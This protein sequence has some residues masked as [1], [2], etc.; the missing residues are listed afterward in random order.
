M[1]LC[2]ALS[3]AIEKL[4]TVKTIIDLLQQRALAHG[5][6]IL[7]TF[8]EDGEGMESHLSYTALTERVSRL[9]ERLKAAGLTGERVLLFYPAGL[10][11]IVGFFS[12]LYAGITAVPLYPPRKNQSILRLLSVITDAKPAAILTTAQIAA[13]VHERFAIGE[14]A[15]IQWIVDDLATSDTATA[16]TPAAVDTHDI[17]FLQ[18]T[19]GS[20]GNPK[21]V[22]V[23]HHNLLRNQEMIFEAYGNIERAVVVGWLPLYH[24]MGLIGNLLQALYAGGRLCFMSPFSFLQ[25]PYR[26]LQ[27]I[28]RYKGQIC[29]G[30]NFAYEL[31]ADRI[32]EA[33]LAALD[34]SSWRVAFNGAEPVHAG[35][36][37]K[38][39]GRFSSCGFRQDAFYPCY[40]MA[41]A[42]LMVSGTKLAGKVT[43]CHVD[44]ALMEQ[45]ILHYTERTANSD[46]YTRLVSCGLPVQQQAIIVDPLTREQQPEHMIGEIWIR[47]DNVT[48]GY[49]N[50]ETATRDA[51]HA[52]TT[53]TE[54]RWLRTGDLG[55]LKNGELYVTG[56]LKDLIIIRG[57]NIYPQ[58][59]ERVMQDAHPALQPFAGA[60]FA[61]TADNGE[62]LVVVQELQRSHCLHP[63]VDNVVQAIRTAITQHYEIPVHA[64][65]LL[66]TGTIFKTSSGKIQR[67][68]CK[69]AFLEGEGLTVLGTWQETAY[70]PLREQEQAKAAELPQNNPVSLLV[71]R[72]RLK[73]AIAEQCRMNVR[74][75]KDDEGFDRLGLDSMAAVNVANALS[76][77]LAIEVSPTLLYD[78]PGIAPLS[79]YLYG[80]V[81]GSGH[82]AAAAGSTALPEKQEAV[83]VVGMACRFP[84]AAGIH[85]FWELLRNGR[86]GVRT[87]TDDRWGPLQDTS[88]AFIKQGGFLDAIDTFDA[89]F[90]GIPDHEAAKMDPQQRLLLEVSWE[91]FEDAG[92]AAN[93]LGGQPVG[94]FV[95]ISASDYTRL[96]RNNTRLDSWNG[97]GN[98]LSIAANRLSYFYDLRGPSI[99]IDTACSSSLVAV[100]QARKSLL[101]GECSMAVAAGVNIMSAPDLSLIFANA[102]MLSPDGACKTFD[103]AAN[104]YVRGEGCGVI[105]LKRLSD[106]ERDGDRIYGIMKGSAVNQD[107]RTNGL[108]APNGPSQEAVI[109]AALADAGIAP[110][111]VNLLEAHGTGTSLGDPIEMNAL[112]QV[113][114]QNRAAEAPCYIGSVKTNIGHLEAAAG[115]A[116]LMKTLLCL[117]HRYIVPHLHIKQ[118]NPRIREQQ[119]FVIPVAATPLPDNAAPLVAGVSAFGFGGTNAHVVALEANRATSSLVTA[120]PELILLSAHNEQAL[121]TRVQQLLAF[122]QQHPAVNLHDVAG[123]CMQGRQALPWRLS[124]TANNTSDLQAKLSAWLQG[125]AAPGE[126][127]PPV[128]APAK[129]AFLFTGQGS[130]YSMMAQELYET[131]PVFRETLS[132]CSRFLE[133]YLGV[134]LVEL[135]YERKDNERIHETVITQP[136]LFSIEIS[137]AKLWAS[138]GITPGAVIGHSVGEVAAACLAGVF[139]LEDA[140]QLIATRSSLMQSL[141][142]GGQM[143]A[144]TATP[145]QV[146]PVIKEYAQFISI[147]SINAPQ[148]VIISGSGE[149]LQKVLPI[150][151][152]MQVR[153]VQL[154]VSHAF[155]SPLMQPIIAAF[156]EKIRHIQF[157]PPLIPIVSNVSGAW[158]TNDICTP[159]Y[160][161]QHILAPVLFTT[162]ISVLQQENFT[163][164]CETGPHPVLTSLARQTLGAAEDLVMLP[165]I[166]NRSGNREDMLKSLGK[167]FVCGHPVRTEA[168]YPAGSFHKLSLPPYPFQRKR[169]WLSGEDM[170]FHAGLPE[171][172]GNITQQEE[173][174]YE[175]IWEK[176]PAP[177]AAIAPEAAVRMVFIT[178]HAPWLA[179]LQDTTLGKNARCLLH[180]PGAAD[181]YYALLQEM[182]A[183]CG[184][185]QQCTIILALHPGNADNIHP[186]SIPEQQVGLLLDIVQAITRLS[187]K[188]ASCNLVLLTGSYNRNS[189]SPLYPPAAVPAAIMRVARQEI[190]ELNIKTIETDDLSASF[191]ESILAAELPAAS[192][193][194]TEVAYMNGERYVSRLRAHTPLSAPTSFSPDTDSLW[195]ITGA[196][197]AIAMH[198]LPWLISKG[199]RYFLLVSRRDPQEHQLQQLE[200]LLAPLHGKAYW[201]HTDIANDNALTFLR[202]EI[203]AT[204]KKLEGIVHLAGVLRDKALFHTAWSDMQPVFQP[205]VNGTWMLHQLSLECNPS[206]FI[207]FS[208]VAALLG[209]AHQGSYAAANAF[210]DALMAWRRRQGL[211]AISIQWGPWEGAGM[212][213]NASSH[214]IAGADIIYKISAARNLAAL[215]TVLKARLAQA[216]V[217][218]FNKEAVAQY[219]PLPFFRHITAA[220]QEKPGIPQPPSPFFRRLQ[221]YSPEDQLQQLR[222]LII[223]ALQELPGGMPAE[224]IDADSTFMA[225]GLD[226]TMTVALQQRLYQQ[227]QMN[228]SVAA[229]YNHNTVNTLAAFLLEKLQ[230]QYG[231]QAPLPVLTSVPMRPQVTGSI[232][233]DALS[234]D[235]AAALLDEVLRSKNM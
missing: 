64:V 108:T 1:P 228:F 93:N 213:R 76:E 206:W 63:D 49:W 17:A 97:T 112:Q 131:E 99:A 50:N 27:A 195:L 137:L 194:D 105:V 102:G 152:S 43:L 88:A 223:Q 130:Q 70:T 226:S 75:I 57:R 203:A 85:D 185:G 25:K 38:F 11:Y 46:K 56:R 216:A 68:A 168:I 107:G 33:Q 95:G 98:A 169:Y 214:T 170:T 201:C 65:C 167:L 177:H 153:A 221:Q 30:P 211:S 212:A 59:I 16:W 165:S 12:C 21:G 113:L 179:Y 186:Y 219:L 202:E 55:F 96:Q 13:D 29:G 232:D 83:A 134:S 171:P 222:A 128:T 118:L 69:K 73:A 10:E 103:A 166:V 121:R 129:L 220:L 78:Y 139:S 198:L 71:I 122:L 101:Q 132:Y 72:E 225:L 144:L 158:A 84:G 163:V 92:I 205:K 183:K 51:F 154:K 175:K 138:W 150:F 151:E 18:Y 42:T 135:L 48:K 114:A 187:L 208:S 31:C 180:Q 74:D 94:I 233:I 34:L 192:F 140:L 234:E 91:A 200:A 207:C 23:T 209:A 52:T 14:T 82:E 160:W 24:D 224:K 217:I 235:A 218:A 156:T 9:G 136:L 26:W 176:E 58:D 86:N 229:L 89:A 61:I 182:T 62:K 189:D 124:F 210:M 109:R 45:H 146:Q 120:R 159:A 35:T 119:A 174:L 53:T 157:R 117:H 39:A 184:Q 215:D 110:E 191:L 28:S 81:N 125:E 37:E 172:A 104:G 90:F 231:Q 199:I 47:G 44:T 79:L 123:T 148:Q 149:H 142:A 181:H 116:G 80:R 5:P 127:M 4:F 111:Q 143:W 60:A 32:T 230:H 77:L 126:Y 87:I 162:G 190:P 36:L 20:T 155:H 115:I 173:L 6:E 54:Q 67:S 2:V 100:H 145:E 197:S 8:L 133:S 178:D 41:E 22:M 141:P 40:G 161:G 7:Y 15:H 164:F 19:S 227:L 188:E 193:K 106:A 3:I 66:R 204:G 196:T 147:A